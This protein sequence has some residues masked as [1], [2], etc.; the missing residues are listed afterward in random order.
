MLR[1]VLPPRM[2]RFTPGRRRVDI[3]MSP[4]FFLEMTQP[5][6]TVSP[7][8]AMSILAVDAANSAESNESG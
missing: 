4:S 5:D 7:E 8:M 6:Q 2:V 1:M 3:A